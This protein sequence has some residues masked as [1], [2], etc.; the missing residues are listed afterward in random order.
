MLGGYGGSLARSGRVGACRVGDQPQG[1]RESQ[2]PLFMRDDTAI[3]RA[4]RARWMLV[5]DRAVAAANGN[6]AAELHLEFAEAAGASPC[7]T[8]EGVTVGTN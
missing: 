4:V 5:P 3:L 8:R 7:I 6:G 1:F 2:F